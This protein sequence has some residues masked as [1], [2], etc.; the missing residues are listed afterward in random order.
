MGKMAKESIA[1]YLRYV[2]LVLQSYFIFHKHFNTLLMKYI[3]FFGD[4]IETTIDDS[5]VLKFANKEIYIGGRHVTTSLHMEAVDHYYLISLLTDY[6]GSDAIK[7]QYYTFGSVSDKYIFDAIPIPPPV[8]SSLTDSLFV[9]DSV[10]SGRGPALW[11]E[12]I[13]ERALTEEDEYT[14][15][16]VA[17]EDFD[18]FKEWYE[19]NKNK[20]IEYKSFDNLWT[21]GPFIT[22][23]VAICDGIN[24]PLS[25]LTRWRLGGNDFV[26][27]E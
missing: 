2:I 5:P 4:L 26:I 18:D 11:L 23:S 14:A 9:T 24:S 16:A 25:R 8:Y 3:D 17:E 1:I 13:G 22:K 7:C 12:K 19:A 27:L 10:H 20:E 15:R 6:F 21:T